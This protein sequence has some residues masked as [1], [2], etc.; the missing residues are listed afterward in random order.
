MPSTYSKFFAPKIAHGGVKGK[1]L[2]KSAISSAIPVP[3]LPTSIPTEDRL[4]YLSAMASLG[5]SLTGTVASW[6]VYILA[7]TAMLFPSLEKAFPREIYAPIAIPPET[8]TA[9]LGAFNGLEAM[10]EEYDQEELHEAEVAFNKLSLGPGLPM[11]S[12]LM[13]TRFLPEEAAAKV[14]ASH[15]SVLLFIAGK[16]IDSEDH[17][18]LTRN[19]PDALIRKAHMEQ[20]PQLLTGNLRMSDKSHNE[21][22]SAW[23]ELAALRGVIFPTFAEFAADTTDEVQDLIYTTMHLLRF[24][25][26]Q[27]AKIVHG[28][29]GAF[30]WAREVPALRSAIAK[31]DESVV[32]AAGY[33]I[34]IQPYVKLIYG[35]KAEIFPRKEMEVLISCAVAASQETSPDIV[36]FYSTDAFSPIVEAFMTERERRGHVRT[37]T[38]RAQEASLKSKIGITGGE[39]GSDEEDEE[40]FYQIPEEEHEDEDIAA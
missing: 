15:Y 2:V 4:R 8:V 5:T 14:I 34:H 38:L 13:K 9:V 26:M 6:K 28:F 11:G 1:R 12:S 27:H 17:S 35:D 37:L 30:P 40:E 7:Y 21:L 16:R 19:R 36:N 24:S 32:A 23:Q 18:A 3:V 22:N 20:E 10:P 29:L 25:G 31:F 39:Q 33:P